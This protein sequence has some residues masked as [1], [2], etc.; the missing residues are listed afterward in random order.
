MEEKGRGEDG[1]DGMT[2]GHMD[3]WRGGMVISA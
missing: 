1:R 3:E 2:E